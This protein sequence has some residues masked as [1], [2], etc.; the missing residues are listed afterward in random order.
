MSQ[1]SR[2]TKRVKQATTTI[3]PPTKRQKPSPALNTPPTKPLTIYVFGDGEF[4]ELGLGPKPINGLSPTGV[5]YPRQNKLLDA[6]GITQIAVGGVHCV[7][8]TRDQRVVTWGVNDNGALGRD[9]AWEGGMKDVGSDD[10][11]EEDESEEESD[12]NPRESTPTAIPWE[13]L[14]EG[15]HTFVQVVA[16]DSASFALTSTGLV[17][18]WGTFCVS[19]QLV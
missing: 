5:K 11:E 13:D 6:F 19:A 4:G 2:K 1:S 14:G 10:S 7:A 3:Q 15:K 12:L 8:L 9:T 18:G 17:F 16:A